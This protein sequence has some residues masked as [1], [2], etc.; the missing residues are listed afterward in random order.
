MNASLGT[1]SRDGA[2]ETPPA[3]TAPLLRTAPAPGFRWLRACGA[4]YTAGWRELLRD[5]MALAM[6]AFVPLLFVVLYGVIFRSPS[7]PGINL[8][9]AA[10]A[11]SAVAGAL[12]RQLVAIPGVKISHGNTTNLLAAMRRGNLDGVMT[13]PATLDGALH[14]RPSSLTVTVDPAHQNMAGILQSVAAQVADRVDR[15]I[16]GRRQAL[17]VQTVPLNGRV[18][19]QFAY[20]LPGILA[21]VLVQIGLMGTAM[22]LIGLRQGG[23]LRQLSATPLPRGV[24]A[25]SQVALRLTLALI[26]VVILVLLGHFA[27]GVALAGGAFTWL[28]VLLLSALGALVMIAL[29]YLLAARVRTV[30]SGNGLVTA[31][32][33]LLV[34]LSG[35]FFPLDIAPAWMKTVS[36]IVPSTYMADALRQVM[37]GATPQFSL[38]I[39]VAAM[40]AFLA[41]LSVAAVRVFQWE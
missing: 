35:L 22:P 9:V 40:V 33:M 37:V 20:T 24:L 39:D 26:Q 5:R 12:Q 30:E 4:L 41:V 28:A 36:A 21:L 15:S 27:L 16:T 32:F 17:F 18:L 19:D 1:L 6:T 23:V 2:S 7:G 34:F 25:A 3:T 10:A 14:G 11:H 13:L 38:G 29:G 31:V 8:G